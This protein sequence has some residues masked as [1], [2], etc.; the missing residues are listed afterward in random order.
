MDDDK[1]LVWLRGE[2]KT[3]PFSQEARL[4]A[5]F[6][7]RRLQQGENL[8]LPHSRPMPSIGAHCHEL[9]IRDVDKNWRIIYRIDEDLIL[10]IEVFSKT[11]QTTPDQ[12]IENCQKRLSKYD[13]DIQD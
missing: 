13:K 8:E 10:I 9:R 5:G 7:L 2:I 1:P 3:P 6:L 4:E 12:I 11:T